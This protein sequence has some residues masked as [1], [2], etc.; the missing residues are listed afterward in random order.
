MKALLHIKYIDGSAREVVTEVMHIPT[1]E[2]ET[3]SGVG[4]ATLVN[5]ELIKEMVVKPLAEESGK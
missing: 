2:Y 5:L 3:R 1:G 4:F